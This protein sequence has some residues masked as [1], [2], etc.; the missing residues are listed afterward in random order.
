MK[1]EVIKQ[2]LK[3]GGYILDDVATSMSIS[4]QNLN[5]KLKSNDIKVGVLE[6]IAKAINKSVD[7]FF[8]VDF[9]DSF[10]ESRESYGKK[11]TAD[12]VAEKVFVKL[13]PQIQHIL[14]KQS[15]I[16]AALATLLLEKDKD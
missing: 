2:K 9:A 1:G 4:P 12:D 16:E 11:I 8:N 10:N 7:Y 6:D 13:Q 14:N 3:D 15:L 5:S